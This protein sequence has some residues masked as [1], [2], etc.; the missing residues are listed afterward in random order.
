M[1]R[2]NICYWWN[3]LQENIRWRNTKV[4]S[5]SVMLTEKECAGDETTEQTDTVINQIIDRMSVA[6]GKGQLT[7]DKYDE[8]V[9]HAKA[10]SEANKK[11][12]C[13]IDSIPVQTVSPEAIIKEM[14]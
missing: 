12:K 5:E 9:E 10:I 14:E 1:C 7:E 3:S 8:I 6:K 4:L 11:I 13:I 2:A